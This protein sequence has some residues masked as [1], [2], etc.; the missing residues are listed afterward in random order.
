MPA[1]P[2]PANEERRLAA[3]REYDI[4]DTPKE[5]SFDR[6][7]RL[8]SKLL[9][10]PMSVVSLVDRE[11]QWFKSCV[12]VDVS[13]TPRG[14]SFCSHVILS[15][16]VLNVPDATKDPRF[17]DSSLVTG[18]PFIRF[19]LGIPLR[20]LSG[21]NIGSFCAMSP[22][23]RVAS[24]ADVAMARELADIVCSELELRLALKQLQVKHS[25]TLHLEKM[26][27]V[28]RLASGIAHEINTPMQFVG[29]NTHFLQESFQTFR[30]LIENYETLTKS[31]RLK[32]LFAEECAVIQEKATEA[33]LPFLFKEIPVA[34][35]Q[36]LEGVTRVK[37]LV[38]AMKTFSYAG[39]D[40]KTC[41]DLNKGI[42]STVTISGNEWKYNSELVMEL[43]PDLPWV[44]CDISE[45][46]QVILNMITNAAHSIQEAIEAG[47]IVWGRIRI[48]TTQENNQ[49]V[50]EV[51][52][53]G[54]G[55]PESLIDKIFDP[56]FTTKKFGMGMGQGL[57]IAHNTIV[58]K[59]K[60]TLGVISEPRHGARFRITLPLERNNP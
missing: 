37:Q 26:S 39:K 16:R 10:V 55:I 14:P 36:S 48:K 34:L 7:T 32:G 23:P 57:A 44:P 53:N 11:R 47:L 41:L 20:S 3:L 52:D 15:E 4:L 54:M 8:A 21:F 59:H 1:A 12:G 5:A 27:S 22:E 40:D 6:V 13:E 19:Y 45:L 42:E 17:C 29:D 38:G 51:E 9:N 18:P 31:V 58:H 25:R 28:G 50:I 60:G 30:S 56:F 49:A 35:K 46:N 43:D 24:E 33:D 2:I